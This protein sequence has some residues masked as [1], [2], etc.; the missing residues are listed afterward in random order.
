MG[1]SACMTA[2]R[3]GTVCCPFT[4]RIPAAWEVK[5]ASGPV[6]A[7]VEWL[8]TVNQCSKDGIVGQVVTIGLSPGLTGP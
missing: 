1:P 6:Q 5:S 4:G 2:R 7:C 3:G 8:I